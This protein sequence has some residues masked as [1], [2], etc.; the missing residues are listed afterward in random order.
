MVPP[1][2]PL[3]PANFAGWFQRIV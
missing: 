1:N 3:V 2:D